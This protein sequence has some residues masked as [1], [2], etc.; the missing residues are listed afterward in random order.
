MEWDLEILD[1]SEKALLRRWNLS[2][3]VKEMEH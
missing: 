2:G 1:W 3:A